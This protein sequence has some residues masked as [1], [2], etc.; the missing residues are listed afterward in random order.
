MTTT[1]VMPRPSLAYFHG[2]PGGPGEWTACA[3]PGLR[4][5]A[6]D[7]NQPVEA[8]SLA[9][10][11]ANHCD[12]GSVTLIGFS[13]GAP[14]ALAVARLLGTRVAHLHLVSPAAPLALG[15]FLGAMAGG[16]LFRMARS[17]PALFRLV[18][19]LERLIAATAPRLLLDRLFATAAGADGPLSRDPGF[20]QAMAQVLRD[21]LGRS[22]AGFIAE[23]TA[24]AA[25]APADLTGITAPITIWQ[26]EADNWTPP[27]MALALADACPV[28]VTLTLLPGCSHYS[29]LRTALARL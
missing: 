1:A 25:G 10:L 23:V 8:E 3:P 19:W 7:R 24:Y 4:A 9:A 5:L 20:R 28:P 6:P 17:R 14:A 18:A 16:S 21:G 15:D 2:Q 29:A 11:V 27:A 12:D 13:L 26:G 22:E